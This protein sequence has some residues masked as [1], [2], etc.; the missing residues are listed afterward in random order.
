MPLPTFL[1]C[2]AEKA[3]TTALFNFLKEH[4][5]IAVS[6]EKELHFFT[7]N[8]GR[9]V[10]WYE[11]RFRNAGSAK[12]IGEASPSYMYDEK[13]PERI[14]KLLPDAKLIFIL[15]HPV[16]R[17]YS[18]YWHEVNRSGR[19]KLS[20]E[21][22]IKRAF[23]AE[24]RG[25][26]EG[27]DAVRLSYLTRGRYAEHIERFRKVFPDEQIL[28]LIHRDL[29][30]NPEK[31][32]RE[33]FEFLG[34]D[35]DFRSE[36]WHEKHNVGITPKSDLADRLVKKIIFDNRAGLKF[37]FFMENHMSPV[38]KFFG[39]LLYRE[40]YPPMKAKIRKKLIEYYAPY[41]RQVEA[42]LNRSLE[43]WYE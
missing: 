36:K 4:P 30:E 43:W 27:M 8:Y 34:V 9:G 28:I 38:W 10:E 18:Q 19:E 31:V 29:R 6:T 41:S 1:I 26:A 5:E 7:A 14:K 33:V 22:A 42:L 17:A 16:D 15:R 3:G 11:G 13:V 40:G 2:G 21:E 32:M 39:R 20:F 12:A 35:P 37:K 25:N 23:E 24:K